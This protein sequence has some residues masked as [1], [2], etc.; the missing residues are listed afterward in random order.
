MCV[1]QMH[2]AVSES[3]CSI[4]LITLQTVNITPY[5]EYCPVRSV[6]TQSGSNL[7]TVQRKL[8]LSTSRNTLPC[9]LRQ[10]VPLK[11]W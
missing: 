3:H 2:T 5:K 9:I 11:C 4:T 7:P 10:H 1:N 8:L 6:I